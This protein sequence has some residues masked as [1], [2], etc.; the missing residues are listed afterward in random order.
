MMAPSTAPC[1]DTQCLLGQKLGMLTMWLHV[2]LQL[3]LLAVI[4]L[5]TA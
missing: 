4:T 1:S 5:H 2:Q 3:Q